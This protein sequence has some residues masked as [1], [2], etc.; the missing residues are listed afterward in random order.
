[1]KRK[2]ITAATIAA[3]VVAYGGATTNVQGQTPDPALNALVKK[4][5][6]TE[7]EAKDALAA[8]EADFKKKPGPDVQ[9]SWKDGLSFQSAG[10]LF[11]GKLGGRLQLDVAGFKESDD[12]EAMQLHRPLPSLEGQKMVGFKGVPA[13]A[14]SL[15]GGSAFHPLIG[16]SSCDQ[17]WAGERFLPIRKT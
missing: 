16:S 2:S 14:I 12:V 13:R 4:G 17:I 11:K 8:A 5:I 6:L 7:K 3:S 10:G 15:P 9:V 1:M